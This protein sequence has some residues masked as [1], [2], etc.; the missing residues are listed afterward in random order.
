VDGWVTDDILHGVEMLG[1]AAFVHLIDVND[2]DICHLTE[3]VQLI[4]EEFDRP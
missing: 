2:L 1:D 4:V 3:G